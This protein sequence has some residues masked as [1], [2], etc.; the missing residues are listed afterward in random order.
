[1]WCW[2]WPIHF[3]CSWKAL[4]TSYQ[5]VCLLYLFQIFF[6]IWITAIGS[7]L[8]FIHYHNKIPISKRKRGD[9]FLFIMQEPCKGLLRGTWSLIEGL[10]LSQTLKHSLWYFLCLSQ[11][12]C[13]CFF[14]FF[15]FLLIW[16][17]Y[18]MFKHKNEYYLY[19]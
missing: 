4:W 1:M 16:I 10:N 14:F 15:F 8:N 17:A 11:T 12:L 19:Y 9:N 7:L 3:L 5:R 6:Y 18:S 13:C 2:N